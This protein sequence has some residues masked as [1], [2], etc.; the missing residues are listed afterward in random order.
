MYIFYALLINRCFDK[1]Q[2]RS[3]VI[4]NNEFSDYEMY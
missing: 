2:M 4:M 1:L 3:M